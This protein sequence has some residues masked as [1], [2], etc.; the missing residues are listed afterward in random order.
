MKETVSGCFFLNTV[1]IVYFRWHYAA[2]EF[3]NE[4]SDCTLHNRDPINNVVWCNQMYKSYY[5]WTRSL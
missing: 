4:A 5:F 3:V 2:G 1:Y